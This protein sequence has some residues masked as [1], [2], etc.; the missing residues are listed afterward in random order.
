MQ[1]FGLFSCKK[2][3]LHY[4]ALKQQAFRFYFV[5]LHGYQSSKKL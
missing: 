2:M 3:F 1:E 5:S 4:F